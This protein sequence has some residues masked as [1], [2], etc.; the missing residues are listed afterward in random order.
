M[1][2]YGHQPLSE[3]AALTMDELFAFAAALDRIV[4]R[5]NTPK[6]KGG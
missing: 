4:E 3:I 5:E 6:P 1:A 2:R